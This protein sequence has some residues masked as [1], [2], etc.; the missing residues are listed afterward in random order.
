MNPAQ[1]LQVMK[2]CLLEM[3]NFVMVTLNT[4][5]QRIDRLETLH[6][7]QN[8][9]LES[10]IDRILSRLESGGQKEDSHRKAPSY[11]NFAHKIT[12]VNNSSE[13]LNT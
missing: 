8:N 3:N 6:S 12:L 10:K 7:R 4:L 2:T 11:H 1:E 5:L 13:L 9:G